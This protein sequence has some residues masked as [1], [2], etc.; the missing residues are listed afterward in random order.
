MKLQA[1][2]SCCGCKETKLDANEGPCKEARS[3]NCGKVDTLKRRVVQRQEQTE[4]NQEKTTKYVTAGG[5]SDVEMLTVLK[6]TGE[7]ADPDKA[8]F[9]SGGPDL[10]VDVD[11][12]AR[13]SHF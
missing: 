11:S 9:S 3:Q 1:A 5:D 12:G 2:R 10:E 13:R 7:D 4:E 6:V 8:T